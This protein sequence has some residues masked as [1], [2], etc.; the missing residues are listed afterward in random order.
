MFVDV[1][2]PVSVPNTYTYGV[3]VELQEQMSV[4]LRVAVEFGKRKRYSAVVVNIH[5]RK[6]DVYNPKPVISILDEKPLITETQL[7]FWHWMSTYYMANIGD[8]LTAALPSA[9]RLSSETE[10]ELVM[11]NELDTK[12][13]S[14]EEFLLFEA[15]SQQSKISFDDA[16]AILDMQNIY[17]V[18]QRLIEKQVITVR[19]SL[20]K[21]YKPKLEAY[22]RLSPLH[23]SEAALQTLLDTLE[24][25]PKQQEALLYYLSKTGSKA[26]WVQ[27][28]NFQ[29]EMKVSAAMVKAL[30]EKKVFE[31]EKREV[32]RLQSK[33][34]NTLNAQLSPA[35][36]AALDQIQSHFEE[37]PVT[38]L[39][40]ITGS[41]KTHI[42]IKLIE[43]QIEN[44]KQVL[45]LLPE[46]ALTSQ[47]IQR[48]QQHFGNEV[49]VYHSKF[50]DAERVEIWNK[51]LNGQYKIVVGARSAVFLPLKKLGLV[52]VDEEHDQS[53]KQYDPA[54]RYHGRDAAI[55]LAHANHAKV[56][57]GS[58]TPS[59]ESYFNAEQGKYGLVNL[60][61]RFGESELPEIE[62]VN[63]TKQYIPGKTYNTF[64]KRLI[65]ELRATVKAN[66]QAI[67]FRNRRGY[68]SIVQCKSCAHVIKCINCDVSLT[69]HKYRD[70]L[71]CH[72]CGYN[73]KV[74]YRCPACENDAL[75]KFGLGTQRVEEELNVF[76]PEAKFGR[77]DWDTTRNKHGHQKIIDKFER[78]QIDVL[79]G[80]QMVTKGLHF[81]DVR[82]VCVLSAD[83]LLSYPDFRS[84]E[85][86]LQLMEQVSG[87]AGRTKAAG[88]VLVQV[89]DESH[90]ALNFLKKHDYIGYYQSVLSE[91]W[92]YRY[93]PYYRQIRITLKHTD[94][95]TCYQAALSLTK[96]LRAQSDQHIKGPSEPLVSRVKNMYLQ[97]ILVTM[98]KDGSVI[99]QT[100]QSIRNCIDEMKQQKGMSR[101]RVVVDV[102]PM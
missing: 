41:G 46:I 68:S 96:H 18:L 3:P 92:K 72:Y 94:W 98:K 25:A 64:S 16:R 49:G 30:L 13:L 38:L 60:N 51:T 59:F 23:E 66:K 81:D 89:R 101:V 93:P 57:L 36:Q 9:L 71:E 95:K 55:W 27:K 2:V 67:L 74:P 53:Y 76:V 90:P 1:I 24:R 10:I 42:Y 12:S 99:Q 28:T 73:Q 32:D 88:L 8:V 39:H 62:V 87:R 48:L 63:L 85:R 21:K 40:G 80:T 5:D 20:H 50:S 19:E 100:K 15:L 77:M 78:K 45:Y 84:G 54:P 4:G 65:D 34:F 70:H 52:V 7:S 58:A 83:S 97:E 79:V 31:Q 26:K 6:P 44:G 75:D 33:E 82:L 22:I 17:P 14:N 47:I 69:Y 37:S 43:E 29:K 35:Q 102:D 11:N 56:L 86:A 91:R 61:E